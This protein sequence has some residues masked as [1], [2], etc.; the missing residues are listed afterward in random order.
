[1]FSPAF[2]DRLWYGKEP[3]ST[4]LAPLGWIYFL[5]M[6]LRRIA[7][8][9]G[10]FPVRRIN[11]PVIVVGNLT[12]GGN[13]KTPL[14]IW[15]AAWLKQHGFHPGIVSR[16]YGGAATHWPQQVR[17]DSDPVMCGDEP[18]LLAQ[19][20]GCPVAA[21]P[22][23][24][25]AAVGLLETAYCDI[26]ISDDGLQHLALARDIE[27]VVIDAER[28]FG[29]GRCLP[30]GPLREPA[31]RIKSVDLVVCNGNPRRGEFEMRLVAGDLVLLSDPS[32]RLDSNKLDNKS[33]HAVAGIGNPD[34]FFQMLRKLGLQPIEHVFPDHYRFSSADIRFNDGLPVIMTEKDAVKCRDFAD[35]RHWYLAIDVNMSDIFEHRLSIL[36]KELG[37]GQ[38]AA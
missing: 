27:I 11:V 3:L 22:D 6:S 31:S 20:S 36:L 8:Q 13:G 14:V 35:E 17:P 10:V 24:Y 18:V 1:M 26:I 9:A 12:P 33:V 7:Y 4:F 16:G 15:L 29:N 32:R 19:R 28:R 38:E 34:R 25:A 21:A 23:R 37:D 5:L 30:A 2:I